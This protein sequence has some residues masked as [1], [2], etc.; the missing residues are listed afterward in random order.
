M[1][2]PK[3]DVQRCCC[4]KHG[5]LLWHREAEAAG[6]V[7][8]ESWNDRRKDHWHRRR[9]L[10]RGA[11]T[12]EPVILSEIAERDRWRCQLCKRAVSRKRRWPEPLSPSLDHIVPLSRGGAHA[13]SNV[14]LAHLRCNVSKGNRGGGEQL[15][16]I[17]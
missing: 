17:G 2:R 1:F 7:T 9:A 4:E 3:R 5:K 12:G 10:K 15:A 6:R 16:L 8:R 14:Q 13:L 11:S